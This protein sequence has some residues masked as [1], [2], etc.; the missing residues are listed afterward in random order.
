MPK[1][2]QKFHKIGER[3]ISVS[4]APHPS[5]KLNRMKNKDF[6]GAFY[7]GTLEHSQGL[8]DLSMV[9]TYLTRHSHA[10]LTPTIA[11]EPKTFRLC[12]TAWII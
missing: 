6:Q 12:T 7:S 3:K 2:S 11:H 10:Q 9:P 5:K 1:C 8:P 4:P